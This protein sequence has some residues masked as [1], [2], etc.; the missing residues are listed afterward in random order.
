MSADD[1]PEEIRALI[2]LAPRDVS[3]SYLSPGHWKVEC[4]RYFPESDS[5]ATHTRWMSPWTHT[6]E[7]WAAAIVQ[8]RR[9]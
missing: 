2:S 1:L 4:E 3:I 5:T 9:D 7:E 6:L 8:V